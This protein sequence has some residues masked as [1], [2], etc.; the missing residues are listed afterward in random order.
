MQQEKMV[1]FI[2]NFLLKT[3]LNLLK[4]L[5]LKTRFRKDILSSKRSR[6]DTLWFG[7]CRVDKKGEK[8]FDS[9]LFYRIVFVRD[10]GWGKEW[11]T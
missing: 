9:I 3:I 6:G 1:S 11:G 4:N 5:Y 10:S 8:T 7:L 2:Y